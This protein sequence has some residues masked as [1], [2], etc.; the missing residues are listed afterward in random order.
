MSNCD[1][2]SPC[3]CRECRTGIR[4]EECPACAF[5]NVVEIEGT[6]DFCIDR[7]GVRYGHLTLPEDP[8]LDLVCR[9][10]GYAIKGIAYYTRVD[11]SECNA[12]LERD[13]L[14]ATAP[15]CALCEINVERTFGAFRA[16][17]LRE[18]RNRK[19]CP[20]CYVD[21]VEADTPDPSNGER[22]YVFNRRTIRWEL[23]KVRRV[24]AS[25]GKARWLNAENSWVTR[26][27][28]CYRTGL[29]GRAMHRP[30]PSR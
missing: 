12:R 3:D 23:S 6:I 10:C 22:K 19:L 21:A 30:Y 24:C 8:A 18:Y 26:C 1:F 29:T 17:E 2:G 27:G 11:E 9:K 25:C 5:D 7:K 4:T 16:V 20:K 14:A 15:P 28:P 13:R